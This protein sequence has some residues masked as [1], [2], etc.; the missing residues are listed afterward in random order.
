MRSKLKSAGLVDDGGGRKS[1]R[2][3]SSAT[4]WLRR[5]VAHFRAAVGFDREDCRCWWYDV[6]QGVVKSSGKS[7]L[8]FVVGWRL[9]TNKMVR[10]S[11]GRYPGPSAVAAFQLIFSL[12]ALSAHSP[13]FRRWRYFY[14]LS[15]FGLKKRICRPGIPGQECLSDTLNSLPS[16]PVP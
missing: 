11:G 1:S 7:P 15:L 4:K 2:F 10:L 13:S 8:R 5:S 16:L 12:I 6:H 14:L 3:D 9:L